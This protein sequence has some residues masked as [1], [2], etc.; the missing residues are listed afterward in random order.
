MFQT[1]ITKLVLH[2]ENNVALVIHHLHIKQTLTPSN[3][4][5]QPNITNENQNIK[6]QSNNM[7]TDTQQKYPRTMDIKE[8]ENSSFPIETKN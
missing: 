6:S 7:E 2:S 8:Y 5:P 4:I 1:V 3:K